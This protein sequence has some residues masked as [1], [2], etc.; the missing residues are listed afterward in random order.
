MSLWILA[1]A[2]VGG[3]FAAP[4]GL[5]PSI[6]LFRGL[7]NGVD[8]TPRMEARYSRTVWG[9]LLAAYLAGVALVGA[10]LIQLV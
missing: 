5:L 2:L 7:A 6:L 3:V 8:A 1:V 4:F 9:G 10:A